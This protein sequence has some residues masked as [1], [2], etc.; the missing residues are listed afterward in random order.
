[1]GQVEG[2]GREAV[3]NRERQRCREP[4]RL[5]Q[6]DYLLP[7]YCVPATVAGNRDTAVDKRGRDPCP[8]GKNV[9]AQETDGRQDKQVRY[10]IHETPINSKKKN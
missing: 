4:E 8:H 9:L 7:V 6:R 10:M 1:M 3:S 2:G 5:I